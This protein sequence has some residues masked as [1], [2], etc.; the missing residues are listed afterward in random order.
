MSLPSSRSRACLD[1]VAEALA[2]SVMPERAPVSSCTL[3]SSAPWRSSPSSGRLEQQHY[4]VQRHQQGLLLPPCPPDLPQHSRSTLNSW[5]PC[6]HVQSWSWW[7]WLAG[8]EGSGSQGSR[9]HPQRD[10]TVAGWGCWKERRDFLDRCRGCCRQTDPSGRPHRLR[11]DPWSLPLPFH[12]LQ[13]LYLVQKVMIQS[14]VV[15]G[16]QADPKSSQLKPPL[17][18]HPYSLR[19]NH[20]AGTP[21]SQ[22][23]CK[24]MR[25]G[26]F[27][28]C[29]D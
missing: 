9:I 29:Q 13:V 16:K 7:R 19:R 1:S 26:M 15:C 5:L 25:N 2:A 24:D 11:L 22:N 21:F 4:G 20:A 27:I 3:A 28:C 10:R 6:S 12:E 8:G 14:G 18:R 17:F 23:S